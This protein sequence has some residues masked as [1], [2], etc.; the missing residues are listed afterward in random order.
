MYM[1]NKQLIFIKE[2]VFLIKR[3]EKFKKII[4]YFK[5]MEIKTGRIKN[6][7]IYVY[8]LKY[9]NIIYIHIKLQLHLLPVGS[10]F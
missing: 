5:I 2:V 6:E 3:W 8:F 4:K 10:G 7:L 1:V 9:F